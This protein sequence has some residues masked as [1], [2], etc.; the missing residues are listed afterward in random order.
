MRRLHINTSRFMIISVLLFGE[1]F[2]GAGR[3]AAGGIS[4]RP[5]YNG[6]YQLTSFFDHYCPNYSNTNG[7][8]I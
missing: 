1:M 4:L 2:V 6:Q 5:P 3:V 7:I 8:V